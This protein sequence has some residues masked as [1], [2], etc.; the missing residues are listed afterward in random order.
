M[1]VLVKINQ[2]RELADALADDIRDSIA[3]P[4]QERGGR[5]GQAARAPRA[6]VLTPGGR[7]KLQKVST[8]DHAHPHSHP[9][10]HGLIDPSIKRSR[11][12]IRA[13]VLSLGRPRRH[14]DRP[15]DHLRRQRLDRPARRPHPQLRRRRHGDPARGRVRLRSP[16]AERYAG[17]FVVAA[18]FISAC[19]AGVEAVSRAHPPEHPH[20]PRRA[21]GRGRGRVRRQLARRPDPHPRRPRPPQP[22][23]GRRRQPRPRR[24]LRQPGRDR[25][26]GRRR[27][28]VADRRPA[29]RPR[30]HR[31]HP[32]HHLAVVGDR[33]KRRCRPRALT[34]LAAVPLGASTR[35]PAHPPARPGRR[36]GRPRRSRTLDGND[37]RLGDLWAD[38]PVV[39]VWLRHYG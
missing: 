1:R 24:R 35:P 7:P 6:R 36:A 18:I 17:L 25:Q 5:G 31:G 10:S 29:H 9:H 33:A 22:G 32:S 3:R 34:T 13:V 4:A 30:H 11:K 39:L 12:G 26:R 8:A 15:D 21:R 37:V 20:R 27:D 38:G 16:R 19:V 23:P 2:T 14:R 28:R